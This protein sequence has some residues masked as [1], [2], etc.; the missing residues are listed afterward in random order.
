MPNWVWYHFLRF[1]YYP[2]GGGASICIGNGFAILEASLVLA[3]IAERYCLIFSPIYP[4]HN[5][6]ESHFRL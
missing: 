2:L 5:E 1:A 6:G 4:V 3:T